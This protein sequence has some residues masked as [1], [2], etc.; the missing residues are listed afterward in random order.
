MNYRPKE[1]DNLDCPMRLLIPTYTK[2][3]GVVKKTFPKDG[4]LFFANFKSYGG[5]ETN[6]NDV[7]HILDTATITT[8]FHPDIKADC[9]IERLEDGAIYEIINEPE[10]VN[11]RHQFLIFK[12]QRMKGK[13]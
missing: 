5:T 9:R 2:V 12:A 13:V 4:R 1:I 10:D 11:F 8:W 7:Y 6:I 3:N